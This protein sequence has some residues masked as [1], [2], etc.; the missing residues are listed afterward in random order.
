MS[1][2]ICGKDKLQGSCGR[3]GP[4]SIML[5]KINIES[6]ACT[7]Y[8]RSALQQG[9][10]RMALELLYIY[11]CMY[12]CMYVCIYIFSNI[13]TYCMYS[14]VM[15]LVLH[16]TPVIQRSISAIDPPVDICD[17]FRSYP[18]ILYN[19]G[20]PSYKLVYNPIQLWL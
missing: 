19:V 11:I 8:S 12:V 15:R 6:K 7:N 10:K 13:L 16:I 20:P 1:G 5:P 9:L 18:I 2:I 3:N 14:F 17:P 4:L